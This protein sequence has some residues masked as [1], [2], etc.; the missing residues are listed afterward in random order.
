M[1]AIGW[2]Y[3]GAWFML[4]FYMSYESPTAVLASKVLSSELLG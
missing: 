4:H 3:E 2:Q 1:V